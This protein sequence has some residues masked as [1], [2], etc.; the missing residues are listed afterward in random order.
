M[1]LTYTSLN[2]KVFNN[3]LPH[4]SDVE[5]DIKQYKKTWALVCLQ[6]KTLKIA[7]TSEF[8]NQRQ[9]RKV[10][11][12]EMIHLV[13]Y[14]DHGLVDHGPTFFQWTEKLERYGIELKQN[15]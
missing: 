14:L 15:Y 1:K 11:A 3:F 12:H 8:R 9:F 5:F 7:V 10:L 6:E 4:S 2:K 13:Q